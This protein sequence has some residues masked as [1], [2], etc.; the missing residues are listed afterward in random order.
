MELMLN[1]AHILLTS[2]L[3]CGGSFKDCDKGHLVL[4]LL[5]REMLEQMVIG[6]HMQS[7]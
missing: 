1:M 5:L 2:D 6:F 7:S 4:D 3:F